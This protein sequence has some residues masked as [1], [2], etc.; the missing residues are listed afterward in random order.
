LILGKIIAKISKLG[1]KKVGVKSDIWENCI[2]SKKNSIGKR[3][4][5]G[6]SYTS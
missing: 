2:I 6:L 4:F 5:I 3:P 1:R